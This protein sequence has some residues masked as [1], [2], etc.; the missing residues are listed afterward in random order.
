MIIFLS[1][2]ISIFILLNQGHEKST[3]NFQAVKWIEGKVP[4]EFIEVSNLPFKYELISLTRDS[5]SSG[6]IIIG[7]SSSIWNWAKEII[8]ESAFDMID[9]KISDDEYYNITLR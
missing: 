6:P 8:E 9:L 4:D 7:K 2:T 1:A 5:A 3:L